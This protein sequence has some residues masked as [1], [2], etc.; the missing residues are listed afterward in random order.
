M[1]TPTTSGLTTAVS[2]PNSQLTGYQTIDALLPENARKW[3]S[4]LG[5]GASVSFSFAWINGV[6]A[7]YSGPN[8]QDYSSLNEPS[9]TYHFGLNASQQAAARQALTAWASVANIYFNE[10]QETSTQVGDIR[11]AWTSA[12]DT[13]SSGS[14]AWGWANYPSSYWPSGGEFGCP[15]SRMPAKTATGLLAPTTSCP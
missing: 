7:V 9:A 3:G 10:V 6:S 2:L 12:T 11:F 14:K 1:P 13:T 5:T 4:T 8:G 15:P